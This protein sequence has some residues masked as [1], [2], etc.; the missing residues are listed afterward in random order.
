MKTASKYRLSAMIGRLTPFIYNA[1]AGSGIKIAGSDG[2]KIFID[3]DATADQFKEHLELINKIHNRDTSLGTPVLGWS[4]TVGLLPET[5]EA[6]EQSQ[7]ALKQSQDALKQSQDSLKQS[8]D[9]L[10]Q[11]QDALKQ[12]QKAEAKTKDAL[13]QSQEA[14]KQSQEALKQSQALHAEDKEKNSRQ[15]FMLCDLNKQLTNLRTIKAKQET[16]N[17]KL[18]TELEWVRTLQAMQEDIRVMRNILEKA[19]K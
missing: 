19:K 15:T 17:A 12:S 8:Q 5:L 14:L 9:A 2:L 4:G 13:K 3:S 1:H 18:K 11:S 10:K 6:L 7:D 16:E